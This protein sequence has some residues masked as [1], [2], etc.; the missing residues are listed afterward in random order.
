MYESIS[1]T[2]VAFKKL[3]DTQILAFVAFTGAQVND[4]FTFDTHGALVYEFG[5]WCRIVHMFT[6]GLLTIEM[7]TVLLAANMHVRCSQTAG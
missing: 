2:L 3:M 4:I 7:F 1:Q 5:F 6:Y